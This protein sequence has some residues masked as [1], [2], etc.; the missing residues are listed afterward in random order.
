MRLL[1]LL[2][3][4]VALPAADSL[5]N[6][7][8][9]APNAFQTLRL[10]TVK[11][12]GWLLNQLRLQAAGLS[13][14][15]DE[16]WPDLGPNS[17][18]LGGTGES[19]ERGPYFLDGLVPLAYL[20]ENPVLIA[21]VK[22][23]LN[24]TLTHQTPEG[25]IGPAK[26]QDWWP[27]FVML[28][29][30]T[31][32]QEATADP[33]VIPL[34]SKYFAYQ[35]ARL[36]QNPL[37]AWAVYR[38]QDEVVSIIWLYNRTGDPALL[39]LARKLH[40]QGKDWNAQSAHFPFTD[41]VTGAAANLDSHGVNNAQ[42]L[43]AAAVWSLITNSADDRAAI[44]RMF[45]VLDRYHRLPNG[46]F[47]ADE[48]FAGE[49]PSQ[50]TELCT[51][52]EAMFSLETNLAITADP[53]FADRLEKI[54]YNALPATITEDFWAHQYD[55]QPNQVMC[56]LSKRNW[57]T[58]GP[59]SNLF[60]LEPNFG[61]C[62]ANMHQGWPK[63]AASLWMATPNNGLAAIVYAP[64]EVNTTISETRVAIEEQTDYP[65]RDTIHFVVR[66]AHPLAFPLKL[67]IPAWA[68]AAH[69]FINGVAQPTPEPG[70]FFEINR[71]WKPGDTVTLQLPM[72]IRTTSWFHN[73]IAVERG[74]L[75][76]SLKIGQSWRQEKRTGPSRDW[77]LFPTTPWNY[78]L[79][80]DPA[81]PAQAFKIIEAPLKTQ[82]F[83]SAAPSV[84]LIT[85]GRRVPDW[86][87][88][89]DSAGAIP[90]S[91]LRCQKSPC[92][93]SLEKLELV[94]YGAAKLRVTA[95]PYSL[96]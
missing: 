26:N 28:K 3:I 53:A 4:S 46:M 25:H 57:S 10:T 61:C 55:Q 58:N 75:V 43:K 42:A 90:A 11:P 79:L 23:W 66:P 78:A 20:T 15:L 1:S 81:H 5:P 69:V 64:S 77:E 17:G 22:K 52:V 14:H 88:E 92:P 6:R 13:G 91:P 27:N 73:S 87:L 60:G 59:E 32:Y 37:K 80:L 7:A 67:R 41:R 34:M 86:Q 95:F 12:R 93:Q 71:T 50:G 51:V 38:W 68:T 21:K 49:D 84:F 44:Q 76:F 36:D 82:P 18:W 39:D 72:A 54:A 63:L 16:F 40:A 35:A 96:Q 56:S 65:F 31:Q 29:V 47:S 30:L 89:S 83:N 19:W 70:V 9:L 2:L 8:P 45:N 74:P 48:H 85:Q 33:R 62:T 94:P 24:W